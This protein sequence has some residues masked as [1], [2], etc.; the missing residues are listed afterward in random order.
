[1]QGALFWTHSWACFFHCLCIVRENNWISGDLN[2][3]TWDSYVDALYWS[4][5]TFIS[6]G[7]GDITPRRTLEK[8]LVSIFMFT[9]ILSFTYLMGYLTS[10]LVDH[11]T[12]TMNFVSVSF[13]NFL[14]VV[15]GL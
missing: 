4:I 11:T 3:D 14:L 6:V 12:R 8:L 5:T 2:L 15:L 1:M 13:L 7:Y 9:N 10:I